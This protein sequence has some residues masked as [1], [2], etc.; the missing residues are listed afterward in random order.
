MY[1]DAGYRWAYATLEDTGIVQ[2]GKP[3][4]PTSVL[5]ASEYWNP[6]PDERTNWLTSEVLPSVR[7]FLNEHAGHGIVFG[8][9]DMFFDSNPD[10]FL[11]WIQ[12]G[13]GTTPWPRF[14]HERVQLKSWTAVGEY[15]SRLPHSPSWWRD[16]DQRERA[17]R[18][19]K[20]RLVRN[21][22]D[23]EQGA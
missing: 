10:W 3:V 2:R 18:W 12:E 21:S 23:S 14:L 16:L 22:S 9:D 13:Y 20:A 5:T 11:D 19:Y 4:D 7:R 1:I 15:V 17:E 8:E 6:E